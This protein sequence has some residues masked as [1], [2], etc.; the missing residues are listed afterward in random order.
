M[1]E[2]KSLSPG[3][4]AQ[5]GFLGLIW[6]A[7]F[8][9]IRVALD[10]VPVV[11]LVL[12][13]V[14]WATLVLWAIVLISRRPVPRTPGIWVAFLVMGML[15]NA[16]PFALM[17][18]GQ[19]HIESGLTA[20]LNTATAI[21]GVTVAAIVFPDERM[22]LRK[23]LGVGLGFLG[24]ATAIGLSNLAQF[25]LKSGAQLAILAA[26][27]SYALAGAWARKRLSGLAPEVAA[28]GMLTGA[29]AILLPAALVFDG[30]PRFD[31]ALRS[32][33]A[34]GYISIVATAGAFLLYYRVLAKA[35]SGNLMLVTLLVAPTAIMLGAVVLG[36]ALPPR[37]FAGFA[38]L[39]TGLAILSGLRLGRRPG[40]DHAPPGP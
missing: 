3:S 39:A 2:Q 8:L 5:L 19:L 27:L 17:T 16:L 32:W 35:G 31:L 18:W 7:S 11:T 21:W 29:T 37:A 9:S 30:V 14:F 34:I 28:A 38:L 25:D 15:N 1:I 22:T 36:E 12:H 6:G 20:I 33:T 23:G 10:E 40:I 26:G 13:R 4:W 24:A